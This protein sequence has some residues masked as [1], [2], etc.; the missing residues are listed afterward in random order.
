MLLTITTTHQPANDLG[1]LLHKHPERFQSFDM[2]KW[3]S[4]APFIRFWQSS[5]PSEPPPRRQQ[6]RHLAGGERTPL[7]SYPIQN[8]IGQSGGVI[9]RA[10]G[11]DVEERRNEM[12]LKSAILSLQGRDD[13][14]R[15]V[16][17]Q[18]INGVKP[19][20]RRRRRRR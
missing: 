16:D 11:G 7:D 20:M 8:E 12:K 6:G 17:A 15:I 19:S 5:S 3:S 2:S 18:N 4:D 14:R 1:F 10:A 9:Q 13:L